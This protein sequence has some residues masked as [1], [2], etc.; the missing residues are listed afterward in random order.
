MNKPPVAPVF[1]KIA[2]QTRETQETHH[3]TSNKTYD[4]VLYRS[5]PAVKLGKISIE[6]D[7]NFLL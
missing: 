2:I 4:S 1:D 6:F 5:L 3:D 7:F